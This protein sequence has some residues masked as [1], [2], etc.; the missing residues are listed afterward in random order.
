MIQDIQRYNQ[1]IHTALAADSL[2]KLKH[3]LSRQ[4][5][6]KDGLE[7][8]N[9]TAEKIL[10]IQVKIALDAKRNQVLKDFG[11]VNPRGEYEINEAYGMASPA[12]SSRKVQSLTTSTQLRLQGSGAV[13]YLVLGSQSF[14]QP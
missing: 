10:D 8:T 11:Q 13:V 12:F 5:E 4:V 3:C 2:S 1:I 7:R 9:R 14:L 6:M